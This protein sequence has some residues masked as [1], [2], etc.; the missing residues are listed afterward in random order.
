MQLPWKCSNLLYVLADKE[1]GSLNFKAQDYHIG[2]SSDRPTRLLSAIG[3]TGHSS[4]LANVVNEN[5]YKP[6]T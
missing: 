2:E 1:L 3:A 5:R 4:S 6:L